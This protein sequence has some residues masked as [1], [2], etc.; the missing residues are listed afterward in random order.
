MAKKAKL[1]STKRYGPRYGQ[2]NKD[3]V[4]ALEQEHRG[5]SKCPYCNYVKVKRLSK[6]IWFCEKCK[7][8]FAGKAYTFAT[9]KSAKEIVTRALEDID[10]PKEPVEEIEILDEDEPIEQPEVA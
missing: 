3:K 9:P 7:A 5:K 6:G 1:G 2:R 10:A 4:A 8:K